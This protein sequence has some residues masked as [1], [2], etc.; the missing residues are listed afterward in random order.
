MVP[1]I[2]NNLIVELRKR[3]VPAQIQINS[4]MFDRVASQTLVR[5]IQLLIVNKIQT[6]DADIRQFSQ[7]Y[8]IDVVEKPDILKKTFG[9]K[10]K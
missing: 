4:S 10:E 9:R 8:D 7:N 3:G 1:I 2:I 5:K 6:K